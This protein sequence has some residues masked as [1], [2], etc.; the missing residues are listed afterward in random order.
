[1]SLE[2]E[3]LARMVIVIQ[4]NI[5]RVK[6]RKGT[7]AI[8]AL[9]TCTVQYATY[10]NVCVIVSILRGSLQTLFTFHHILF[11]LSHYIMIET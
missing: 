11:C 4:S 5:H 3:I 7:K 6:A 8:N 2:T 9:V 10:S 1:M